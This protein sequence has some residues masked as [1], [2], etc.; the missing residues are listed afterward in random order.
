M[1]NTNPNAPQYEYEWQKPA[2]K[3]FDFGRVL[4]RSFSGLFANFKLLTVA[5]GIL[6]IITVAFAILSSEQLVTLLG[7]GSDEDALGAATSSKFWM[8]SILGSLP[9]FLVMLWMQLVVVKTSYS[10][11]TNSAQESSPFASALKL[12]LP[13]FVIAAIYY[14]VCVLGLIFL[15]IG[16]IFVWPGWALAGP[17]LVHEKKGILGSIGEAWTLSKGSKRWILLLLFVLSMISLVAYSAAMGLG[18]AATGMNAFSGNAAATL[19][20]SIGQQII[21][22]LIFGLSSASV[23]ALFASGLTAA[24]V[25]IKSMRG[26]LDTIGEVFS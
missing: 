9:P 18:Y 21:Y 11:F 17:I 23:Y 19:N 26:G 25:E 24:Y 2:Q 20:M 3:E 13:M 10:T 14:I 8:W 4:G 6:L 22:N 16:F 5:V 1:V 7:D 12:V 15:F